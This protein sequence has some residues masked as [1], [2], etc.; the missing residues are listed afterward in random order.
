VPVHEF[1]AGL[2]VRAGRRVGLTD[3]LDRDAMRG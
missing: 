2:D 3:Q 1:A